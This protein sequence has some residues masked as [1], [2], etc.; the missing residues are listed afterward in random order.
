MQKGELMSWGIAETASEIEKIKSESA[1]YLNG[2]NSCGVIDWNTYNYAFD[3]YT[4]LL[5]KAYKQGEKDAQPEPCEDA[6]S[7]QTVIDT[8]R[9]VHDIFE[10][11]YDTRTP[12][13]VILDVQDAVIELPSV[14]PKR[15]V[16]RWLI[17]DGISDAQCSECKMYFKDV[18]DMDNSDAF[19]RNCGTKMEGLKVVKDE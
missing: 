5:M 11:E 7:R 10:G 4:D 12:Y 8:A 2:L 18:Y 19:C 17:R 14:T 16:G 1:D 9:K 3:F 15:K 13:G 6:V